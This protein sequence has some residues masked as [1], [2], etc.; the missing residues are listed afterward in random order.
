AAKAIAAQETAITG[1]NDRLKVL[2]QAVAAYTAQG[3]TSSYLIFEQDN[4][5][6]G[7]EL[8]E[9]QKPE[10]EAILAKLTEAAAAVARL[11]ADGAARVERLRADQARVNADA[12]KESGLL[13]D[14]FKGELTR[15]DDEEKALRKAGEEAIAGLEKQ[16]A[17]LQEQG[18]TKA[19]LTEA[20]VEAL[21]KVNRERTEQIHKLRDQIAATDIGSYRFVARAFDA[22]ATDVVKWL[23]LA[24][25]AV[26]D[27]LAVT[28]V[29][30]FNMALTRGRARPAPAPVLGRGRAGEERP[31][32][33]LRP[34]RLRQVSRRRQ[35]RRGRL[36]PGDALRPGDPR[37]GPG[38]RGG[39][40]LAHRRPAQPD[41]A[42]G[43]RQGRLEPHPQPLDDQARGGP[44]H[45]S[46]RR[47]FHL[48]SDEP[49]RG[50]PG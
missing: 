6:K 22:E 17:T 42:R 45:G 7:Q 30:A 43:D 12:A 2:D 37:R 18:Q 41:A 3:T 47:F 14:Q 40:A 32:P 33:P 49:D 1:L 44:L 10:R 35:G 28:L 11:R 5:K 9:Q 4:V 46:G 50:H 31:R 26:F 48:W 15:L 19:G 13:R 21:Y 8:R 38:D 23:M 39:G 25:V 27:P 20:E 34:L 29:V 24:L 16:L 36:A